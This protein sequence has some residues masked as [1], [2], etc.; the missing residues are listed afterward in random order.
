MRVFT[1]THMFFFFV[2]II[3]TNGFIDALLIGFSNNLK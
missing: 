1:G 2:Q 3:K